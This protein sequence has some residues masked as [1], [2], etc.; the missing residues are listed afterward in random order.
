MKRE[1]KVQRAAL[2]SDTPA[3]RENVGLRGLPGAPV[4]PGLQLRWFDL[5]TALL[6]SRCLDP[7]GRP[8]HRG[9]TV[10]QDPQGLMESLVIQ[11]RMEKLVPLGREGPQEIQEVL[12]P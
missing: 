4:L 1:K 6:C 7:P 3:I 5:G 9:Q 11:E 12:A 2:A 10:L 8:D